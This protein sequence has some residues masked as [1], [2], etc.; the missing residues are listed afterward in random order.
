[1]P[2]IDSNLQ[3]TWDSLYRCELNGQTVH[4]ARAAK[5]RI[6]GNDHWLLR[7]ALNIQPGQSIA[8]IGSGFG[9]VGEDWAAAG[10]GPIAN[11]DTSTWIQA[12]LPGNAIV[13]VLAEGA[14]SGASRNHIRTAAGLGPSAKFHWVISEDVLPVLTD[15]ECLNLGAAMRILGT[16]V[17]HWVTV[18]GPNTRASLNWKTKEAWK[19]L[20]GA[21]LIVQRGRGEAI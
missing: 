1:M 18:A 3:A 16:N 19:I 20:M 2:L 7:E 4:Y 9:W 8:L 15:A 14:L 10:Y 11:T 12:N 21:D 5:E 6:L 17:A 13:P